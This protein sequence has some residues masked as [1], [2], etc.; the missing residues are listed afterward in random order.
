M[1]VEPPPGRAADPH[2][3][4]QSKPPNGDTAGNPEWKGLSS[5]GYGPAV[6]LPLA[7]PFALLCPRAL[8]GGLSSSSPPPS[9]PLVPP[10]LF[11]KPFLIGQH[12]ASHLIAQHR[13]TM[14]AV[15]HSIGLPWPAR[16]NLAAAF[17]SF[18]N[19][20]R[21]DACAKRCPPPIH[22]SIHPSPRPRKHPALL[23]CPSIIILLFYPAIP[24]TCILIMVHGAVLKVR[25][26]S[27]RD[28]E[29]SGQHEKGADDVWLRLLLQRWMETLPFT[30]RFLKQR[31]SP[32]CPSNP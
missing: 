17:A 12:T 21:K 25:R 20:P 32:R 29:E 3:R 11:F 14:S 5:E 23:A 31:G 30:P 7:R 16:H 13:C 8:D 1:S 10:F 19:T 28:V 27:R 2:L 6:A 4:R 9:I 26:I 24:L 15:F 18:S 22:L